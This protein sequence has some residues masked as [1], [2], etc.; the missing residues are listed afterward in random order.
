MPWHEVTRTYRDGYYYV[1]SVWVEF[2]SGRERYGKVSVRV[3]GKDKN[4][5]WAAKS[6]WSI[7]ELERAK[8]FATKAELWIAKQQE[9][10]WKELEL[11]KVPTEL[12]G[13]IG[14]IVQKLSQ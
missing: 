10:Q 7:E 14:G 8:M 9:R 13:L 2:V 1:A 5:E 3:Y 12:T 11:N 4:G 6:Y